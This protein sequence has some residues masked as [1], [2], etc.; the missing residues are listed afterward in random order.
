MSWSIWLVPS[1]VWVG[2]VWSNHA[3]VRSHLSD[4]SA[5]QPLAA[6]EEIWHHIFL[7]QR[8][9]STTA[10]VLPFLQMCHCFQKVFVILPF[11][12]ALFFYRIAIGDRSTG[13]ISPPSF[14]PAMICSLYLLVRQGPSVLVF[15]VPKTPE[16]LAI[17]VLELLKA[18]YV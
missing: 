15:Q 2:E 16:R 7:F 13:S 17:S 9:Q 12:T 6:S 5:I 4:S 8:A 18:L 10:L 1:S 3:D 14:P 11:T